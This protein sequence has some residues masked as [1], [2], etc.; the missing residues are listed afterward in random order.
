M[1]DERDHQPVHA[2][3]LEVTAGQCD[4]NVDRM[5]RRFSRK[6]RADGI[7]RESTSKR[8]FMKPSAARR[9]K[10]LKARRL[11]ASEK[12]EKGAEKNRTR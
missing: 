2:C 10:S 6:V 5:I 12:K 9:M 7:L 11:R 1:S 4:G 8:R 3:P